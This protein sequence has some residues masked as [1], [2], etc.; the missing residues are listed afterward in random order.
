[1]ATG[2]VVLFIC[3]GTGCKKAEHL[4]RVYYFPFGAQTL[5]PVTSDNIEKR[6]DSCLVDT[7]R[8]AIAVKALLAK[9][10][11]VSDPEDGFTNKAV[12]A[13][14]IE[15][16]GA[17]LIGLVEEDGRVRAG[18]QDGLLS[19][20]DIRSLKKIIESVCF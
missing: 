8:K 4:L 1:M 6:G 18:S 16:G 19:P 3:L 12:R 15:E 10:K 14:I 7:E 5:T 20:G 9:A 17:G 11:P 13:K 2:I